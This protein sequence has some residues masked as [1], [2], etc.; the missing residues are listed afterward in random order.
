MDL[1]SDFPDWS[2]KDIG[3]ISG[4]GMPLDGDVQSRKL[5]LIRLY[6]VVVGGLWVFFR[7]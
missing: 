1:G 7:T 3:W 4:C 2:Q 5:W 6:L